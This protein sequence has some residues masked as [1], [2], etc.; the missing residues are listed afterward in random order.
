M[1]DW[2]NL[3]FWYNFNSSPSQPKVW[4][5]MSSQASPA[6]ATSR[7]PNDSP[8]SNRS[9]SLSGTSRQYSRSRSATPENNSGR[10]RSGSPRSQG[11]RTPS[12]H[13]DTGNEPVQERKGKIT[14]W[15]GREWPINKS[16]YLI[17]LV[18]QN[19]YYRH[20]GFWFRR[21]KKC[22]SP[23]KQGKLRNT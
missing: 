4:A 22:W 11:S 8:H 3:I 15:K 20:R 10:S 14:G 7:S 9:R 6:S 1:V 13:S 5:K 19:L 12:S 17:G 23:I 2:K 16:S 18:N 21:W